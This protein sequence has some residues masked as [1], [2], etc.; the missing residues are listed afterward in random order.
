[1][2][3]ID[4]KR[5]APSPRPSPR[6]GEAARHRGQSL[7]RT[8]KEGR[9]SA[10]RRI[11]PW[12]HRRMPQRIQRDAL[13]SRRSTATFAAALTPQLSPRPRF[14]ETRLWRALPA[15]ACP[16]SASSSRT[17]RSAGQAGSQSL[18]GAGSRLPPAGIAPCSTSGIVSRSALHEQG[19][20]LCNVIGDFCQ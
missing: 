12:R 7:E 11:Q 2:L 20:W 5:R 13:A 3:G 18:P 15:S 17:G 14:H 4:L 8:K 16:S 1:V 6:R 9:R 19:D 10:D